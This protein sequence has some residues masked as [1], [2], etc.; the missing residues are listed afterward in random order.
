M[1]VTFEIVF[2]MVKR[3]KSAPLHC[4]NQQTVCNYI[5]NSKQ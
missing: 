5:R 4:L 2:R 1:K 3:R